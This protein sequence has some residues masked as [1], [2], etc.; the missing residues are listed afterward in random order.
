MHL[1]R[2]T[3]TIR[4]L[5][6]ERR[7]SG[8]ISRR[9]M[10]WNC[11]PNISGKT[12]APLHTSR[13]S[14]LSY[15]LLTQLFRFQSSSV[16]RGQGA[17]QS[18]P[19][20]PLAQLLRLLSRTRCLTLDPRALWHSFS[21][22]QRLRLPRQRLSCLVPLAQ[23]FRLCS[24]RASCVAA[25]KHVMAALQVRISRRQ[26]LRSLA[27]DSVPHCVATAVSSSSCASWRV[28]FLAIAF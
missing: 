4:V 16:P 22:V 21:I 5:P 24:A 7:L 25:V 10:M 15:V 11:V 8:I 13:G 6:R 14:T 26:S 19:P 27:D 20:C 2:Y 12:N 28:A 9:V 18:R 23:L 1:K 17:W 3:S